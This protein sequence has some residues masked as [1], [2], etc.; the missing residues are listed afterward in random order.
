[1]NSLDNH[2]ICVTVV[3]SKCCLLVSNAAYVMLDIS[4]P[5]FL[6]THKSK[7]SCSKFGGVEQ[8]H[9]HFSPS[10]PVR[11]ARTGSQRW[12][13]RFA[14]R[15]WPTRAAC[16]GT[17]RSTAGTN[18]TSVH[19]V[20]GQIFHQNSV[21]PLTTHELVFASW[22]EFP[23]WKFNV[24]LILGKLSFSFRLINLEMPFWGNVL[25][26]PFNLEC[27]ERERAASGGN[28]LTFSSRSG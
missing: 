20:A 19:T 3:L 2:D 26:L 16:T 4:K 22:R 6:L 18:L 7:S 13:A 9:N 11:L 21:L 14:A 28:K 15:S 24:W 5:C 12:L 10:E 8:C 1:M 23:N 25:F 27:R 17:G